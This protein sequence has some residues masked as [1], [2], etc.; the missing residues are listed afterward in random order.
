MPFCVANSTA[1]GV[2][3]TAGRWAE[4]SKLTKLTASSKKHFIFIWHMVALLGLVGINDS[5]NRCGYQVVGSSAS[6]ILA[7]VTSFVRATYNNTPC[8]KRKATEK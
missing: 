5:E 3:K 6:A 1:E 4:A 2:E 7:S 8:K